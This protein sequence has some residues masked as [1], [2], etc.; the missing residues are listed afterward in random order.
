[1]QEILKPRWWSRPPALFL[2]PSIALLL[3]LVVLGIFLDASVRRS[4]L[5]KDEYVLTEVPPV[6]GRSCC[7]TAGRS[8]AGG[9]G[10][11]E[12]TERCSSSAAARE[13]LG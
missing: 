8:E 11:S 2:W 10:G 4:G 5:W 12:G 13:D 1:M 6:R 3:A 7:R 9:V